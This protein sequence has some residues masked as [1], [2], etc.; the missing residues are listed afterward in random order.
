V[1]FL[2][3]QNNDDHDDDNDDDDGGYTRC[4]SVYSVCWLRMSAPVDGSVNVSYITAYKQSVEVR[5]C[6]E[7]KYVTH[8]CHIE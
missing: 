1:Y 6:V 8:H 7:Q 5:A 4:E 2:G 3:K